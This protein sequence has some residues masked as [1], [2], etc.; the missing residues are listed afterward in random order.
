MA[1]IRHLSN[2]PITEALIDFRVVLPAAFESELFRQVDERLKAD[3]PQI[4]ERKSVEALVKFDE[5]RPA[6]QM[7]D[8]GLTGVWIKS[9]DGKSIGQFRTDGFTFNRLKPYTSW[10]EILPTALRLWDE[11]VRLASPEVVTR[12]ALRYINHLTLPSTSGDLDQ[13]ITT[14]PRLPQGIPQFHSGFLTRVVLQDYEK[15]LSANFTQALEVGIQTQFPTLLLDI[16]AY[17]LGNLPPQR[18]VL[19]RHLGELRSYKNAI[20]FGSLT[21]DFIRSFE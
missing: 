5:G 15:G 11:Y 13:L 18:E 19:E 10:E 14:V 16:D 20:F 4:E 7:K 8:L 17:R 1:Q 6:T 12:V 2:A 3:F 21:E 9:P